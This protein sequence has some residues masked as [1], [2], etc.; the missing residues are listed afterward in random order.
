MIEHIKLYDGFFVIGI[1]KN[2]LIP[3]LQQN[4]A[5]IDPKIVYSYPEIKNFEK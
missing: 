1:E 2:D 3:Y 4:M 5:I